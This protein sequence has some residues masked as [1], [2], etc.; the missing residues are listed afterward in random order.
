M[1]PATSDVLSCRLLRWKRDKALSFVPPDGRFTL[2]EYRYLPPTS[3][4]LSAPSAKV[5]VPFALKPAVTIEEDGGMANHKLQFYLDD[6]SISASF[7]VSLTSRLS[8]RVLDEVVV[9]FYLGDG[10]SGVN[11]TASHG[12]NWNFDSRV[13]KIRWDLK[14]IPPSGTQTLRGSWVS[15]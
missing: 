8:T 9:E 3:K 12:T 6:N 11:C 13:S 7:S 2:M 5:P 10:S 14:N 15:R 4:S 1:Y